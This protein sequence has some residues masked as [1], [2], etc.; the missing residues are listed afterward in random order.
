MQGSQC[1]AW[2]YVLLSPL[3]LSSG[4]LRAGV[5]VVSTCAYL[6]APITRACFTTPT[7]IK[8]ASAFFWM[9]MVYEVRA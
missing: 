2:W 4:M 9:S 3:V 7:K 6:L 8:A 1:V 5:P